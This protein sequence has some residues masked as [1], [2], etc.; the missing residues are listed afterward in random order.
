MFMNY[1][2]PKLHMPHY[3]GS[4]STAISCRCY[5]ILQSTKN[6]LNKHLIFFEY[7]LPYIISAPYKNS[8]TSAPTLQICVSDYY[9]LKETGIYEV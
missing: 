8:T 5:V 9:W 2:H 6:Y 4:L 7:L 3:Y 1:L